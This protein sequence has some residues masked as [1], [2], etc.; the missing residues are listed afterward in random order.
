[1]RLPSFSFCRGREFSQPPPLLHSIPL[2]P[3]PHLS[4]G[5]I[6]GCD[7]QRS[8]GRH[9]HGAASAAAARYHFEGGLPT[10]RIDKPEWFL[11]HITGLVATYVVPAGRPAH[12]RRLRRPAHPPARCRR[13]FR[14]HPAAHRAPQGPAPAPADRRPAATSST[15]WTSSMPSCAT[16]SAT[17]PSALTAWPGR[18]WRAIC[19]SSTAALAAGSK[20]RKNARFP[21][22]PS[23]P[24]P[25]PLSSPLPLSPS[26]SPPLPLP[27][28]PRP[29]SFLLCSAL[30]A[31]LPG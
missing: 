24:P 10:N 21:P 11:A 26:L 16:T 25:L 9:R 2:L 18:T 1:M 30:T 23:P 4:Q 5:L 29:S 14:R 12:P 8:D 3:F 7:L 20:S 27:L 6:A 22:A 17:R 19:S 15:R 28:L 13:R 31:A